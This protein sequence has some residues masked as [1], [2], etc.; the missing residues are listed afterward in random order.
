MRA[1]NWSLV[2]PPPAMPPFFSVFCLLGGH[3]API[4]YMKSIYTGIL[5]CGNHTLY[6]T[7]DAR[8]KNNCS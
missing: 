4:P 5:Y 1:S 8:G 7:R 6:Y 2:T 3:G